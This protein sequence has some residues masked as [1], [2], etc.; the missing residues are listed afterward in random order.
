S[1]RN[2]LMSEHTGHLDLGVLMMHLCTQQYS[3]ICVDAG[4][5]FAGALLQAGLVDELN[6]YIAPEL[7]GSDARGLCTLPGLEK[8]D[9]APQF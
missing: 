2:C 7:L 3:S 5:T 6:V 9:D 4:P 8:V 1:V